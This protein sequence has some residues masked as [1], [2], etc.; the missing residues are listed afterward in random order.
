MTAPTVLLTGGAGQLAQAARP[1][2]ERQGW[3]VV[4]HDIDELDIRDRDAVFAAL[5]A[6][7]PRAVLNCAAIRD[8]D[9][10]EVDVDNAW[11]TNDT[12]VHTLAD[13]CAEVESIL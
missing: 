10:C 6:L 7:R 1:A 9:L 11:A 13:A 3:T 8:A 2:F 4:A 5:S 12:A